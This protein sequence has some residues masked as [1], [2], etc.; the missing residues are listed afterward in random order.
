MKNKIHHKKLWWDEVKK[1]PKR[2]KQVCSNIGKSSLG[3]FSPK[4]EKA[5]GWKGGRYKEGRDGY[6]MIYC[7]NG[8]PAYRSKTPHIPEHRLVME[9]ELGRYLSKD[10]EVH[11]INGIK[12]DNRLENLE[13]VMK[14]AHFGIVKCPHCQKEFKLK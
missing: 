12:D 8:H 1:D 10:E 7:P 2:Y 5:Y 13:L 6:I 3:R 9:K 4:G 14:K 11:H